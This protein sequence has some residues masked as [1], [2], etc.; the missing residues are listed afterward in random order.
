MQ[1][2]LHRIRSALFTAGQPIRVLSISYNGK[3][4]HAEWWNV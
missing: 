3:D 2:Y 4:N 1:K